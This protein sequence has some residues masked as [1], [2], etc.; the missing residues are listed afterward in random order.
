MDI[1]NQQYCPPFFLFPFFHLYMGL[2]ICQK[3]RNRGAVG[4]QVGAIKMKMMTEV[5]GVHSRAEDG[6][7]VC[8]RGLG[9]MSE[10]MIEYDSVDNVFTDNAY[11]ASASVGTIELLN[12]FLLYISIKIMKIIF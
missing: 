9:N 11:G 8:G 4:G 7:D 1:L 5:A 6:A 10:C 12:I 2:Y 3:K